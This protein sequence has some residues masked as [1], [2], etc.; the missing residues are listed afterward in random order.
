VHPIELGAPSHH[1][2]GTPT[3][4]PRPRYSLP[5]VPDIMGGMRRLPTCTAY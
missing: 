3:I 5:V 4:A 1:R 2:V